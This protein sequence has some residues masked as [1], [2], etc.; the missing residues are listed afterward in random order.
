MQKN[1]AAR[2][3]NIGGMDCAEEVTILKREIGPLV[4][5]EQNL[6]FDILK[7]RMTVL[8]GPAVDAEAI[9]RAVQKTGM[10]ATP[11][12]PAQGS[13]AEPLRP[14]WWGKNSRLALTIVSGVLAA[15]AFALHYAM[16]GGWSE[17][18]GSE[19]LGAAHAVP[20]P[21]RALYLL[22]V[23]AGIYLVLPKALFSLRRARPDMNLLMTVAVCGAIGI[24][25]WFEAATVAFLFA[26]SLTLESWSVSRARRAI[27]KLLDLAPAMVR[28]VQA[29]GSIQELSAATAPLG[30]QFVVRP[31]ERIALDGEVVKGVSDVNQA[32]ITGESLPVAKEPGASVFAGTV[33]GAGTLEVKSTKAAGDTTLANIIRLVGEAQQNRAPSEQWVDRFARY[34]TPAVL[35]A[36][37]AV[38]VIPVLLFG[39]PFEPWLYQALVLLV[40]AC[41]CALVI[42]TP[43]SVVAALAAAAK[44]GVLVKGGAHMETPSRL[45][46]IAM[47]KTGTLTEG[48]PAVVQVVAMNGH[49]ETEL[50]ERAAAMEMHSD[51][52]LAKAIVEYADTRGIRP[53]PAETFSITVGKGATARLNGKDYW[54]GSHRLLE[55]RGQETPAVHDEIE[56]LARTGRTVVVIG[57]ETHV[58]G[59]LALADRIR[60]ESKATVAEMRQA[61]IEHVVMLTG[62]NRGT[63]EVIGRETGV[64]EVRAD[65]LPADKLD[66]IGKL[67][68]QYKDVA[69]IGDGI[70]DAPALSRATLGIA[71]GAAGS[72]TAMEAADVALMSDDLSKIPWLIRH[73]RRMMGIILAN[74]ALSLG[75]K[76]VF[77]V[78]TVLGH[79]SLWAAI[80][81]DMGVSLLVIVNALRLLR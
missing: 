23:L 7:G 17:V 58:C 36:A 40:I 79:A 34:Y 52:P 54:L 76:A 22:A 27:E 18:L 51:H 28:V 42:S 46:A 5:G 31:G 15:T 30:V 4:G 74:I 61:G 47:D 43:V 77:V 2:T 26:L 20:L 81:A 33:N 48:R 72:D 49:T 32:P 39:K 78:L 24:G 63:A 70:N 41:P 75:V 45:K 62:D 56:A 68:E 53:Q 21:V 1:E 11:A 12:G 64:A 6:T 60:A 8:P 19:G 66:A 16:A 3:L 71:M 55:E 14:S 65:L 44:N 10:S 59:F 80:A 29:D 9:I 35:A 25:E 50:L 37:I 69:M 57:N 67:V 38:F 13:D 73:S